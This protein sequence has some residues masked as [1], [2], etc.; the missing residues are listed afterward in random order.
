MKVHNK[1]IVYSLRDEPAQR[2]IGEYFQIVAFKDQYYL[3]YNCLNTIKLVISDTL[4]FLGESIFKAACNSNNENILKGKTRPRIVIQE[5]PGGNFCIIEND[6]RLYMLCGSHTSNEEQDEID[7]P[8]LVWPKEK[9]T[10]L[11]PETKRRD[12]RNGMYLLSSDDGINWKEEHDKPVLHSLISSESCQFGEVA[13][14][15]SPYLIKHNDEFY[16]YGRLNS[17]LDE[18]RIYLRKSKDLIEWTLPERLNII[19]ENNNDMSK[20]YYNPVVFKY[21]K[22]L[23]MLTPYFE[24]IGTGKSTRI[25]FDISSLRAYVEEAKTLLLKSQ[26]G[27][28]WEIIDSCLP[29]EEKYKRRVNDICIQDDKVLIFYR[30]NIPQDN[31]YLTSYEIDIN[32]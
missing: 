11:N 27:L 8:D 2:H 23:Y 12:R 21:N 29:H 25:Y 5:A 4:S 24:A 18:R 22:Q 7:I 26:D 20:N 15:T 10:V 13:F 6:K 9:R 17:S 31:Q 30:E 32:S 28:S 16:Y 14:D 1:Q 3:Y 19:N